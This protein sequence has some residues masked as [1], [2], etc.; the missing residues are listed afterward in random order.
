MSQPRV[1]GPT[2]VIRLPVRNE[3]VE[4]IFFRDK[5][6]CP[7]SGCVPKPHRS[8]WLFYRDHF[9]NYD[10]IDLDNYINKREPGDYI[11]LVLSPD[12]LSALAAKVRAARAV[13]S[14]DGHIPATSREDD[15][16]RLAQR[17]NQ[18]LDAMLK[19]ARDVRAGTLELST[20]VDTSVLLAH[21]HAA[22]R[23]ADGYEIDVIFSAH[24][25][26][27]LRRNYQE[28]I[29]KLGQAGALSRESMASAAGAFA[30]YE[31]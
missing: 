2:G 26:R 13:E 16:R 9:R 7:I 28:A 29:L 20:P 6:A 14:A 10:C 19:R 18:V 27:V 5:T 22:G 30:Q 11:E 25:E 15:E 31:V 17:R 21:A 3:F 1:H 23:E 8:L 12:V 24:N 4:L